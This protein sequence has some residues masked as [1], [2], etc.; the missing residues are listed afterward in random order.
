M[1]HLCDVGQISSERTGQIVIKPLVDVQKDATGCQ[2]NTEQG[3][4]TRPR[5]DYSGGQERHM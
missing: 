1:T 5:E 3:K 2:D 4:K